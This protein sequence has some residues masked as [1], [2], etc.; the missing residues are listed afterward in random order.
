MKKILSLILALVL[1]LPLYACG[2]NSN[3]ASK[4]YIGTYAR[5][6]EYHAWNEYQELTLQA[7]GIGYFKSYVTNIDYNA[8]HEAH[9]F[10]ITAPTTYYDVTWDVDENGY[11][12]IHFQGKKY[13]KSEDWGDYYY[14]EN[15]F[16]ES[17]SDVFEMKGN[18][19]FYVDGGAGW[20]TKTSS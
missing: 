8:F 12:T 19:L 18:Q 17:F 16:T 10:Y 2:E 20:L 7:D 14:D 11:I 9:N 1:L 13:Y 15:G 4:K 3:H 5:D 6:A